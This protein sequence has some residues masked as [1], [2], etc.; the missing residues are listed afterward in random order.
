MLNPIQRANE[1]IEELKELSTEVEVSD[2]IVG[3][4]EASFVSMMLDNTV[5]FLNE[6]IEDQKLETVSF[7]RVA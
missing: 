7:N 1:L 2:R 6:V 3:T 4:L 5:S